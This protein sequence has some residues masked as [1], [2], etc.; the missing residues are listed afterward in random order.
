MTSNLGGRASQAR[1][2][3]AR[4]THFLTQQLLSLTY[5]SFQFNISFFPAMDKP[6]NPWEAS[7]GLETVE[8]SAWTCSIGSHL[9]L[10]WE[11]VV[12]PAFSDSIRR[13]YLWVAHTSF[14]N[15]AG[16]TGWSPYHLFPPSHIWPGRCRLKYC[17]TAHQ[18][19]SVSWSP[20]F[21][22]LFSKIVPSPPPPLPHRM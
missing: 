14:P 8:V 18:V 3:G 13:N 15:L 21:S 22:S 2:N 6:Y 11:L 10:E 9:D 4:L 1:M 16:R 12:A 7:Q 19:S 17:D 5:G 20:C